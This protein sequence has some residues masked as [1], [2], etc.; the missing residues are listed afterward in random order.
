[1]KATSSFPQRWCED[2]WRLLSNSMCR[3]K[4]VKVGPLACVEVSLR[5][6]SA[7]HG[8]PPLNTQEGDNP[9]V[10]PYSVLWVIGKENG[11]PENKPWM[12]CLTRLPPEQQQRSRYSMEMLGRGVVHLKV[13]QNERACISSAT[14]IAWDLE[15]RDNSWN[16]LFSIFGLRLTTNI[17]NYA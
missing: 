15:G 5:Q 2:E 8:Q 16:S 11:S 13:A 10:H 14:T 17:W 4:F 3:R 9:R 1:M 12:R 6:M 7:V